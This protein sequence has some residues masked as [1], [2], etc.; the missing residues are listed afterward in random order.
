M[1]RSNYNETQTVEQL[2]APPAGRQA[3]PDAEGGSGH[4]SKAVV[5]AAVAASTAS[6]ANQG[7]DDVTTANSRVITE[8]L[9]NR[10]VGRMPWDASTHRSRVIFAT[11]SLFRKVVA[12]AADV[13]FTRFRGLG[14]EAPTAADSTKMW[15]AYAKI[16]G[17]MSTLVRAMQDLQG[18]ED[19]AGYIV[20]ERGSRFADMDRTYLSARHALRQVLD[21]TVKDPIADKDTRLRRS[22][23]TRAMLG[24][25]VHSLDYADIV[26]GCLCEAYGVESPL[27][28]RLVDSYGT[29]V[30]PFAWLPMVAA[31]AVIEAH[32]F[33]EY[34]GTPHVPG[35]QA[36]SPDMQT[37]SVRS[38]TAGQTASLADM[39]SA[40]SSVMYTAWQIFDVA[41]RADGDATEDVA[42]VLRAFGPVFSM[43]N[44]TP[45]MR[46]GSDW[47]AV[48]HDDAMDIAKAVHPTL[49][50][51]RNASSVQSIS[52]AQFPGYYAM[53]RVIQERTG[54]QIATVVRRH[55][56]AFDGVSLEPVVSLVNQISA[57]DGRNEDLTG[58][59]AFVESPVDPGSYDRLLRQI[60]AVADDVSRLTRDGRRADAGQNKNGALDGGLVSK[61][62]HMAAEAL[63]GSRVLVSTLDDDELAVLASC[64]SDR[65]LLSWPIETVA[66]EPSAEDDTPVDAAFKVPH[67][68]YQYKFFLDPTAFG[69]EDLVGTDGL[70]GTTGSGIEVLR[71]AD[72]SRVGWSRTLYPLTDDG[73]AIRDAAGGR[74]LF[75]GQRPRWTAMAKPVEVSLPYPKFAYD[76]TRRITVVGE[77]QV[78]T[79]LSWNTVVL[80]P[81]GAQHSLS[82]SAHARESLREELALIAALYN[83]LVDEPARLIGVRMPEGITSL[84]DAD[85]S[86]AY[87]TSLRDGA[88]R[89]VGLRVIDV[90]VSRSVRRALDR[91]G[92]LGQV[93]VHTPLT[94]KEASVFV[95][96][97][98]IL[99]EQLFLKHLL[100]IEDATLEVLREVWSTGSFRVDAVEAVLVRGRRPQAG[101]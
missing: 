31:E 9:V 100:G 32:Q 33:T 59:T 15:A 63:P 85:D 1:A 8:V 6:G 84:V 3:T 29:L 44:V 43:A 80:V 35:T 55:L 61:L 87:R 71:W 41:I 77:Q 47:P 39:L 72:T 7:G 27:R 26:L 79:Q 48:A 40:A 78:D 101:A 82:V 65:V 58:V 86:A 36:G 97:A 92:H 88:R 98:L 62:L 83:A 16:S 68:G 66:A 93:P 2:L 51:I 52:A 21:G 24:K 90:L 56:P 54:L 22:P 57:E 60:G 10:G 18:N 12:T 42:R 11:R 25:G 76:R 67:R 5:D 73:R 69:Y 91:A 53:Q 34:R 96:A 49:A 37:A 23:V 30:V 50:L 19:L 45:G 70:Y 89:A 46:L 14:S 64:L 74:Y 17:V 94:R 81:P 38:Y 13:E 4:A 99:L 28:T 20:A 75:Q 95:D